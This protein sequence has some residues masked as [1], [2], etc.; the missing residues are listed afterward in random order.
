MAR[1][2]PADVTIFERNWIADVW[3]ILIGDS[4][5]TNSFLYFE[6]ST[7]IGRFDGSTLRVTGLNTWFWKT[8][9]PLSNIRISQT[10]AFGV[11]QYI[12]SAEP[13]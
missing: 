2:P 1:N 3:P 6:Y 10:G 11:E 8:L 13:I 9:D 4:N 5:R 7:S 12:P